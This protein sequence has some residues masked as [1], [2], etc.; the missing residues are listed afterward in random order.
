MDHANPD[1]FHSIN[2][3]I[4]LISFSRIYEKCLLQAVRKMK[5]V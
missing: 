4:Q 3:D 5:N 2:V 1:V